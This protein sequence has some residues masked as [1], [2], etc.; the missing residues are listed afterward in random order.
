MEHD[1]KQLERATAERRDRAGQ[2]QPRGSLKPCVVHRCHLLACAIETIEPMLERS[3]IVWAKIFDVEN[4]IAPR[5]KNAH[6]FAQRGRVAARENSFADPP[7][8]VSL[9]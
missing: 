7:A 3:S 9:I 5:L 6:R 2:V 8:E 1:L 4:R